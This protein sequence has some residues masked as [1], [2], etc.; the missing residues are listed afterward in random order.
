MVRKRLACQATM[1]R[2][3]FNPGIFFHLGIPSKSLTV[4]M[5]GRKKM[6]SM[7]KIIRQPLSY[8]LC[9]PPLFQCL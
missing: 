6:W 1:R 3:F 5:P 7:N 4:A 9:S 2:H 8:E